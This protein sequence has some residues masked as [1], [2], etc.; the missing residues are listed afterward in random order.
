M[1]EEE[2]PKTTIPDLLSSPAGKSP[3]E[4]EF[5]L[6]NSKPRWA[7][8][9]PQTSPHLQPDLSPPRSNPA[10][11]VEQP[12]ENE[13]PSPV[14]MRRSPAA[15][16]SPVAKQQDLDN[17]LIS[18]GDAHLY[19]T[20]ISNMDNKN[21]FDSLEEKISKV[22]ESVQAMQIQNET[23]RDVQPEVEL[24]PNQVQTEQ[25]R[26]QLSEQQKQVDEHWQLADK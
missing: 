11:P 14:D 1:Q 22:W 6:S 17:S 2:R 24:Q 16:S 4:E 9:R 20:I 26:N 12:M 3:L 7:E 10:L 19:K 25:I 8:T 13:P 18:P 5:P 23:P 15:L 21:Y